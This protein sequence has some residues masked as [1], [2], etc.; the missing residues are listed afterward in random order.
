ML[1]IY[2]KSVRLSNTLSGTYGRPLSRR[3]FRPS[4]LFLALFLSLSPSSRSFFAA[5]DTFARGAIRYHGEEIRR[6]R[7]LGQSS[8]IKSIRTLVSQENEEISRLIRQ[9]ARCLL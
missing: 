1:L 5:K 7:L 2:D 8:D 9:G 6:K 4:R 3:D